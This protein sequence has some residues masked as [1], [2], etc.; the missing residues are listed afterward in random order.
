MGTVVV[1]NQIACPICK[2]VDALDEYLFRKTGEFRNS[3]KK[4]CVS[5]RGSQKIAK[6]KIES[7]KLLKDLSGIE[8]LEEQLKI[9]DQI[10]F[11]YTKNRWGNQWKKFSILTL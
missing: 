4:E 5:C 1:K 3:S 6:P 10:Q 2:A 9:E 7:S 8:W 11:L